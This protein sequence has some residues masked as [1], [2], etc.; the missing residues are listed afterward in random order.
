MQ[1]RATH[2]EHTLSHCQVERY[3]ISAVVADHKYLQQGIVVTPDRPLQGID[4]ILAI[5]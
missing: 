3:E 2:K 5:P 1:P 4:M